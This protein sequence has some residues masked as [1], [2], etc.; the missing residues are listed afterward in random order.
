V[1]DAERDL[2]E[3]LALAEAAG[4]TSLRARAERALLLFHTWSGAADRARAHGQSAIALAEATGD[5]ALACSCHWAQAV[6]EGL[7]GR[8]PECT[9]H[10]AAAERLNE[11]IG[12]PL[13]GLAIAEVQVECAFGNGDWDTAL[14]IGERAIALGRSLGQH[15]LL[16]RLLVWTALV[17]LGRNQIERASTH[18]GEAWALSGAGTEGARDVH[19]VVPAH[20]G[21]ASRHIAL[22]ELEQAVAVAHAAL[23]IVDRTG[24]RTWATHRLLPVLAEAHLTARDLEGA[25][26]VG[27]RLREGAAA[28]TD[29]LAEAWA[30][31]CDALVLWLGGAGMEAADAL[32][33]AAEKL[34]A[35]P[36]LPDALRLRRRLA[37]CLAESGERERAVSE[38]RRVHE[39]FARLGAERELERTRRALHEVGARPPAR[40]ARA[41]PGAGGLTARERQILDL[42]AARKSNK[43]IGRELGISA[44]T[45]DTHLSNIFKKLEVESRDALIEVARTLPPA[46]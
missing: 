15:A 7:A 16:P 27:A 1:D 31:A 46:G 38:L 4:D 43:A 42:V 14:A 29:P 17:Y 5:P 18:L 8:A 3:A 11:R 19:S 20:I 24:Y 23:A 12:S 13:V 33:A 6:L 36:F 10:L 21:I 26:A 28:L 40:A 44:R 25:R 32:R 34:A 9:T 22:G 35:I 37:A 45:V 39:G 30:D 2:R 41:S